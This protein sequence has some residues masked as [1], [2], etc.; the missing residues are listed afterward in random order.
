MTSTLRTIAFVAV[1]ASAA[2]PVRSAAP[3]Q[4]LGGVTIYPGAQ[5]RPERGQERDHRAT[6]TLAGV[7]VARAAAEKYRTGASADAVLAFYRRELQ[8]FGTV[9]ECRDGGNRA[10]SVRLD[11]FS[12]HDVAVCR[13]SEF[14]EGETELKAERAGELA[15]VTVRSTGAACEFA[16]I[17]VQASGGP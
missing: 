16:V 10:S 3:P 15:V 8:R 4:T 12:L 7:H 11:D 6:L 5:P 13:P 9:T 1:A 2:T 17:D 14:G